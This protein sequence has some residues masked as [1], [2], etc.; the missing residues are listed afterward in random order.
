MKKFLAPLCFFI[1]LI[2]LNSCRRTVHGD[3]AY[4]TETRDIRDAD[5]IE[6]SI[7]AKLTFIEADSF[8]CIIVAQQNILEAIKTKTNGDQFEIKSNRNLSTEKPIQ[9]VIS[10]PV[11]SGVTVNGS[12]DIAG[13][14][15]IKEEKMNL[16]INGS[17]SIQLDGNI[18]AANSTINGSG[19]ITLKG[20]N[21]QQKI[22]IN[23]SGDFHAFEMESAEIKI[24]ITGSGDADV[25][26]T[27]SLKS[28]ITGSGNI[29]YKGSPRIKSEIT[30]SGTIQKSE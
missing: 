20:K 28:E 10:L 17:G 12:G 5:E 25:F 14:N 30:G 13:L 7:P 15:T 6:L 11:L 24:S 27:E 16:N 2:S 4:I 23:G 26:A 29:R 3:G 8:T 1:V 22:A 18:N 19:N 21:A 9:I